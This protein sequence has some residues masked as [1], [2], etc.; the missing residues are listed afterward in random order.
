MLL[1]KNKE[2]FKK[3]LG[4]NLLNYFQGLNKII[5]F[6]LLKHDQVT[7]KALLNLNLTYKVTLERY[8]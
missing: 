4:M 6:E 7:I 1:G 5:V 2:K 8:Y 3:T